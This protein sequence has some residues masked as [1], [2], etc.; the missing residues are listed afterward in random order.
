MHNNITEKYCVLA[1]TRGR[2]LLRSG[3]DHNKFGFAD[4][5]SSGARG[6]AL[7]CGSRTTDTDRDEIKSSTLYRD[8]PKYFSL[9]CV[10]RLCDSQNLEK[11]F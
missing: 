8:Q 7:C 10:T 6:A 5:E 1:G 11:V 3:G 9:G 2:S 4:E